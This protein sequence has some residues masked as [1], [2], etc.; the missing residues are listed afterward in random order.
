MPLNYQTPFVVVCSFLADYLNIHILRKTRQA[1]TNGMCKKPRT[2][3]VCTAII[4]LRL[5]CYNG[6]FVNWLSHR[7]AI[8][9]SANITKNVFQGVYTNHRGVLIV[10]KLIKCTISVKYI[11]GQ[12]TQYILS[13]WPIFSP[14]QPCSKCLFHEDIEYVGKWIYYGVWICS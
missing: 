7:T 10:K 13:V 1:Y 6:T 8:D 5:S 12:T 3:P 9:H 4:R 2:Q 11:F 14:N